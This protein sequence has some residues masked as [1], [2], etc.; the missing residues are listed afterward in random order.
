MNH[1]WLFLPM[2]DSAP[3]L[4]DVDMLRARYAADGYLYLQGVLDV[5]AVMQLRRAMLGVL[6]RHG[7]IR[8]GL[9]LLEGE[10]VAQPVHE[11][12]LEYAPVY[13]DI[14]RLEA[15]HTFA[16]HPDL[17]GVMQAVLGDTAFP[18]PL[19]ICRIGFPEFYEATTPPHQDYPNNQGTTNLTAAWIPVGDVPID[20]GPVAILR[21]SHRYGLL[22][23][24]GHMGPGRRQAMVP[25]RML[26][27]NRWVT[28]DFAAGDVLVFNSLTVHAA[29]HNVTEFNLRLSVDYRYQLEGEA[30]TEICL[31]PHFQRITWGDVY[32]R[33]ESD[34]YQ[35][36]WKDLAYE[37]VPFEDYPVDRGDRTDEDEF[38]F[39]PDEWVEIMTVDKRWAE[40]YR[41]KTERG[42]ETAGDPTLGERIDT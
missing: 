10:A 12:M 1:E 13:D 7:W 34:E 5:E 37:V 16:H 29:L 28:T 15:F 21:G 24:G 23:L 3:D 2:R 31:Q 35:Y 11:S 22:P 41:R 9:A 33:W 38:G 8:G 42:A 27:E 18:H 40:R 36:Y 6:A 14:Q 25:Q 17:I 30:L 32:Q 19:K 26:E 20:L 39:T 4:D